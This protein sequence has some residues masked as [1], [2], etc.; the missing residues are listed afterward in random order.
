MA[1]VRIELDHHVTLNKQSH[2]GHN[3][4]HPDIP[5][6][7]TVKSGD[8]VIMDT[9]DAFDCQIQPKTTAQ[10]LLQVDLGRVHPLTGPI[11]VQEAE[12]G[13]ILAVDV[14]EIQPQPFAYTVN[15]PGFGFLRDS[16]KDPFIIHWKI[17]G[18]MATSPDLPKVRIQGNPF[19][20]VMGTSP[21]AEL[22]ISI[23]NREEKLKQRGGAV[24]LP[25]EHGAVPTGHLSRNA[26]RTIA[27]HETGG[28]V[29]IKQLVKGTRVYIPVYVSGALFSAGDAHFAQ[30]D[31]ECCGTAIEMGATLSVRFH[32]L[33]GEA[34]LSGQRDISF[35]RTIES[36]LENGRCLSAS[37]GSF[38]ATTGI[39]VD[40]SADT[41]HSED[42]TL[43]TR[44]ALWN[45]IN[46]LHRTYGY[47]TLQAYCLCSVAVD[48]HV[49]QLPDIPNVLVSAILPLHIFQDN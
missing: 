10:D 41:N 30:G 7:A 44:N 49:S 21:S 39:C 35:S 26:V 36:F 1:T 16:M 8:T 12:P 40:H 37:H 38:Y 27:P 31:N 19:M 23:N 34:H 48:F 17:E 3:R 4:W 5:P 22:V 14:L 15:I 25:A 28:N 47:S 24:E 46:Y 45:M 18:N 42:L 43:A 9:L 20:G 32:V 29:D 33:K 2:K 13:D 6:V 11:Y